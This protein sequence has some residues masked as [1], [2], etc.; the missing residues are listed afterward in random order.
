MRIQVFD[1]EVQ[2]RAQQ[3]LLA[4]KSATSFLSSVDNQSVDVLSP[5]KTDLSFSVTLR[6]ATQ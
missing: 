5:T 2:E 1:D 4:V 3:S 6:S